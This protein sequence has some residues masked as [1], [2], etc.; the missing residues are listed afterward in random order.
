MNRSQSYRSAAILVLT[1]LSAEI[2]ASPLGALFTAPS[3]GS[4]FPGTAHLLPQAFLPP[5]TCSIP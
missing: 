5:R 3:E 4:C 1:P 2:W